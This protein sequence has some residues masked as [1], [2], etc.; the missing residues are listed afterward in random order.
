MHCCC[1]KCS[2]PVGRSWPGCHPSG[3]E[4][5]RHSNCRQHPRG[6]FI[7]KISYDAYIVPDT[8][9]PSTKR[10]WNDDDATACQYQ[11]PYP[12]P[13]PYTPI[14]RTDSVMYGMVLD[15][16]INSTE[17]KPLCGHGDRELRTTARS[18]VSIDSTVVARIRSP[19]HTLVHCTHHS[20]SFLSFLLLRCC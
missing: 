20:L 3:I 6:A 8:R 14:V 1:F 12:Y 7:P 9:A 15:F 17:R 10:R 4:S 13:Y 18:R 5:N 19:D 16:C 2:D 11:Y